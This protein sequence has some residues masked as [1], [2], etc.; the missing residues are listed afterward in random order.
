MP[1]LARGCTNQGDESINRDSRGKQ[2]PHI[3]LLALLSEQAISVFEL[4]STIIGSI[5]SL[6]TRMY[7][8]SPAC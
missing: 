3:S 2:C 1:Q 4:N 5:L 7:I 8:G 6:G